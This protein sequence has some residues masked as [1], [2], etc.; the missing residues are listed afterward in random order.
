MRTEPFFHVPAHLPRKD[1]HFLGFLIGYDSRPLI[2]TDIPLLA[3]LIQLP[4]GFLIEAHS[5]R[6]GLEGPVMVGFTGSF[7]VPRPKETARMTCQR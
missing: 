6:Q 2:I 5:E 4:D 7:T 1:N 3:K